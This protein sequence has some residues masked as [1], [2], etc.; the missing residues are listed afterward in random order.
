MILLL[1]PYQNALE[2]AAQIERATQQKVKTID[3]VPQALAAVREHEFTMVVADENLL[4][5]S[6]GSVNSMM[7][8][9]EMATPI[10]ID[11]ACQRPEKIAKLVLRTAQ[12]RERETEFLRKQAREELRSEFKSDVTGLLLSSEMVLKNS[13][14]PQPAADRITAVVEIAKRMKARLASKTPD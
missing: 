11:L 7:Q 1:S 4:E 10:V 2:C 8:R 12:R 3:T 13:S 5:S 6:P 9:M 14:L